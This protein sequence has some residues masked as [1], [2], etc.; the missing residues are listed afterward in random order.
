MNEIDIKIFKSAKRL[1]CIIPNINLTEGKEYESH[2]Y[3]EDS[4]SFYVI[5]DKGNKEFYDAE[6]F[7]IITKK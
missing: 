3:K 2:G 1:R 5:D 6:R 4:H 7:A